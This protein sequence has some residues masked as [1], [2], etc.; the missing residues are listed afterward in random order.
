MWLRTCGGASPEFPVYSILPSM[1]RDSFRETEDSTV[2]SRSR[3]LD[4]VA[5]WSP[6]METSA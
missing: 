5:G 4:F 3:E 1:R 6:D 2:D